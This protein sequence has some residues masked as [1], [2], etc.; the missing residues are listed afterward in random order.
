M[1]FMYFTANT[2]ISKP[3]CGRDGS[4][5]TVPLGLWGPRYQGAGN[6]PLPPCRSASVLRDS[7]KKNS[8]DDLMLPADIR[9]VRNLP[10]LR[11]A[12]SRIRPTEYRTIHQVE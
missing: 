11:H 12:K 6:S 9:L 4:Y 1:H 2:G 3:F 7:S 10:K 8:Q 5:Q